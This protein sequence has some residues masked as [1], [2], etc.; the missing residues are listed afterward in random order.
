MR[1]VMRS[2]A[3]PGTLT[4]SSTC[5]ESSVSTVLVKNGVAGSPTLCNQKGDDPKNVL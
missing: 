5:S 1:R 2:L 3:T 4:A